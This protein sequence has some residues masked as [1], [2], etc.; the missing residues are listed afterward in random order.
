VEHAQ[1]FGDSIVMHAVSL[2]RAPV[3][4]QSP[5][6]TCHESVVADDGRRHLVLDVGSPVWH[7][8]LVRVDRAVVSGLSEIYDMDPDV[9]MLRY[10]SPMK[11]KG[12]NGACLKVRVPCSNG[13]TTVPVFDARTNLRVDMDLLYRAKG[14]RLACIV[15]LDSAWVLG[16]D[17]KW[18]GAVWKLRQVLVAPEQDEPMRFIPELEA[19]E[20]VSH[21]HE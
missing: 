3:M 5:V 7:S 1:Q 13:V 2:G 17:S 4:V 9:A 20:N 6:C 21:V 10:L 18:F 16:Q 11:R 12:S 15:E 19:T 14:L 8:L